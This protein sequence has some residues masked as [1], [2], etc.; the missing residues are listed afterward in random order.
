M[1]RDEIIEAHMLLER[2]ERV[3]I[4]R[5]WKFVRLDAGGGV[6]IEEIQEAKEF[7]QRQ[8]PDS[9][10]NDAYSEA[11]IHRQLFALYRFD[12]I[13]E[14]Q[15][16]LRCYIS[17]QIYHVCRQLAAKYNK[18]KLDR[19]FLFPLVLDD[20]PDRTFKVSSPYRSLAQKILETFDP[21]R[22]SLATWTQRLVKNH[23]NLNEF[24]IQ[25]GI[26]QISKWAILNDTKPQ[27]L[28]RIFF[29]FHH[30]TAR[31]IQDDCELLESYH[32]VYRSQ[33]LQKRQEEG[34]VGQCP[35]PTDRQL[36]QMCQFLQQNYQKIRSPDRVL[37]GLKSMA[38]K[39]K[40]YR[41][42]VR[43]GLL[44]SQSIEEPNIEKEIQE[45]E[46]REANT[47]EEDENRLKELKFSEFYEKYFWDCIDLSIEGT[48]DVRLTQKTRL[49]QKKT[50][51]EIAYAFHSFYCEGKSQGEIAEAMGMTAQH[52]VSRLL[53]LKSFRADIRQKM[54]I[55]LLSKVLEKARAYVDPDRLVAVESQVEAALEEQINIAIPESEK[56]DKSLFS[57]RLCCYLSKILHGELKPDY[58]SSCCDRSDKGIR[59]K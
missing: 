2:I 5:Y 19:N 21:D 16:C 46:T 29:N 53:K 50:P 8:F 11:H 9:W 15:V 32:Q 12:R 25:N 23:P 24:L 18:Y 55:L 30:L 35:E 26:Y 58:S 44:Q 28:R 4:S 34:F 54:L 37:K 31:E 36:E 57:S 49:K 47:R 6:K 22:A 48:L 51:I 40:E 56:P 52:Q 17:E 27:Q 7:F 20:T 14:A 39:L 38:T 42:Y 13:R 3:M 43:G 59:S 41:I 10:N 45:I 33:R 1:V